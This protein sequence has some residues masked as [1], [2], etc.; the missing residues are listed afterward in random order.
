MFT[1]RS[2]TK[3]PKRL[4]EIKLNKST[5]VLSEIIKIKKR[6]K[7]KAIWIKAQLKRRDKNGAYNVISDRHRFCWK[8]L[9]NTYL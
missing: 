6:K 9:I 1:N 3:I 2:T 7:R 8:S 5:L 4:L